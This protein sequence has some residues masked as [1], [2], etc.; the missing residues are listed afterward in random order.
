MADQIRIG[1]EP[2]GQ[3]TDRTAFNID[4][5]AF[6]VLFNAYAWRGRV[7]RK[8][9]TIFLGQLQRQMQSV[10]NSTP[11]TDWQVGQIGI[12]DGSG[13]IS[14][15]LISLFSLETSSTLAF[16]PTSSSTSPILLSD[17]INTYTEPSTPDGTLIGTP[18]GLGTINYATGQITIT[19]GAPVGILIGTFSYFPGLPVMGLKDFIPSNTTAQYPLQ[20]SFDTTYSYQVKQSSSLVN[21]YTTNFYKNSKNPVFWTGADYQQFWTT[22]YQGALWATNNKP[23]FHFLKGTYISGSG[24][25]IIRFQFNDPSGAPFQTL[26]IN[27]VLWFNEWPNTTTINEITG[28]V[29]NIVNATTGTYDVTFT[30]N[31]TVSG[32]G[33]AQMLTNSLPNKDGIRWYDGDPTGGTGLPTG[34][35]LGWVNFAP[36]LTEATVSIDNYTA[37]KYYL[38]GAL[39][40]SRFKDR[41]IFF[42]PFIQSTDGTDPIL[43]QDTAL[44]SQNGTPYYTVS[45]SSNTASLVPI[46]ETAS[47]KA[48][49]VDQTG[50]GGFL[51]AGISQ[52]IITVSNNEDVLLVGFGGDGRKTRFVY[53]G[54]DLQP[55][56]FFSINSELPSSATFSAIALDKGAIDIGQYGIAMTDQQSSQRIDLDIPDSVFQIQ[57]LNN[58]VQRVNAI[59]DFFREWI[60]FTYPVNNSPTKFPTQSF[61]FN[62]RDN[63]WAVLYENYTA[64]GTFRYQ[65]KNTWATIGAKFGSWSNWREPW[66]SGSTSA[67]FPSIIGGNPQGYVLIK[68][69]GTG[70]ARSGTIL[71]ITNNGGFAQINSINHCVN[72]N[73]PNTGTGDYLYIQNCLGTPAINNL[74]GQVTKVID[75]NNFVTDLPFPSGAYLGLG[76]FARLSQPLIQTKQFP[77]YWDQGRQVRLGVQKYL[78][79]KTAGGQIT[80]NIYLSQDASDIWNNGAIVPEIDVENSS[81]IY[82]Q[83]VYTCPES[84]NLGLTPANI[85]LQ[86]PISTQAQQ[87]IWHRMNTSLIG[88]SIQIGITLDDEQMRNFTFATDEIVLHEMILF[89]DKGPQLS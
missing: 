35:G 59:R 81:L 33:I 64:Q 45:D 22:N 63:T 36:P 19:G 47:P 76:T 23:G 82:S 55:F 8:R 66:N 2:R 72:S 15:N 73:N 77:F 87:Q 40:I 69:E 34:T 31:Q 38:V 62:Y 42:S 49:I 83:T 37:K 48:F 18:S 4:N 68:S 75:A 56:L 65:N 12:L 67:Q 29:T 24:T 84:T 16:R 21:F 44:W 41:L 25:S 78:L 5:N 27:D 26:V 86:M 17:G 57:A 79:D 51:P 9:G 54:N 58:G 60:Y 32:I 70:E 89:I 46:N 74:V 80:V 13:N 50:F 88:D 11:P 3:K 43:L 30:S 52:P 20:L 28:T 39:I 7:K 53:T 71:A 14:V 10:A 1:K 61:L 6:P 85:N